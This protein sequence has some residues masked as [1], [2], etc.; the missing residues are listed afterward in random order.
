MAIITTKMELL[1][2][3]IMHYFI[4]QCSHKY[5][6]FFSQCMTFIYYFYICMS[7]AKKYFAGP[8]RIIAVFLHLIE[9]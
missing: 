1:T 4:M 6:T 3:I 9:S 8:A 5:Q 2:I 7:Y